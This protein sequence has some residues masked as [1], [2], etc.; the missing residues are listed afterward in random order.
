MIVR[1][2]SAKLMHDTL[3]DMTYEKLAS[4][5]GLSFMTV[6]RTI[7][8]GSRAKVSTL[9]KICAARGLN[10]LDYITE[11]DDGCTFIVNAELLSKLIWEHELTLKDLSLKIGMSISYV[12]YII[13]HRPKIPLRSLKRLAA[14]LGVDWQALTVHIYA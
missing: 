3:H 10:Y 6:Y 1:I 11:P 4:L 8:S 9:R 7:A 2:D 14:E 5:T 13:R 12:G